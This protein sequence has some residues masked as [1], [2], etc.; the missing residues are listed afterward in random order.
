MPAPPGENRPETGIDAFIADTSRLAGRYSLTAGGCREFVLDFCEQAAFI[1]LADVGRP[2]RFLR[3]MAG[4]PPRRWGTEGFRLGLLDDTNP[5]RHY[6]AFLFVGYWLPWLAGALFLWLWELAGFLR[7]GFYWSVPDTRSGFV[8]LWH[9]RL[10]RRY[11]H[12][13]LPSLLARDLWESGQ[14]WSRLSESGRKARNRR[15]V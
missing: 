10:L 1:R 9:G 12:T 5:A 3:Q 13:I 7:Y 15:T 2:L 11:G 6:A 8:G 14:G 4:A